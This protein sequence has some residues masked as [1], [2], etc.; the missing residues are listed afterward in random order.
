M[1]VKLA[2]ITGG[3]KGLGFSLVKTYCNHGFQVISIS[4]S[5]STF[6]HPNLIATIAFDLSRIDFFKELEKQLFN[7]ISIKVINEVILINNAGTLGNIKTNENNSIKNIDTTIKLNLTAPLALTSII[8]NRFKNTKTIVYNISSGAALKPYFGWANYCATKAGLALATKTIA[9]E[10][11]KN[12]TF[13]IFSI[14]PGIIDTEMQTK[15]RKSN[16]S[17]F[18]QIERFI[19]LK[20]ENLLL[21]PDAVAEKIYTIRYEKYKSGISITL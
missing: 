5:S 9:I 12:S 21:A 10:Q 11:E 14:I 16:K 19:Q 17:D 4:R 3:S 13:E 15:I 8:T 18:K 2:I 6:K 7:H 20:K 1:H